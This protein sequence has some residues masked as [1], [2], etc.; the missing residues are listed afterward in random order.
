MSENHIVI[1]RLMFVLDDWLGVVLLV[2]IPRK[3]FK[4]LCFPYQLQARAVMNENHS[5][6]TRL[7]YQLFIALGKKNVSSVLEQVTEREGVLQAL[8]PLKASFKR[9]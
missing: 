1:I 3:Y 6:I 5:A 8:S 9:K 2:I 4:L 7:M